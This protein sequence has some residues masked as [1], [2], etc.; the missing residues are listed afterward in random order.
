MKILQWTKDDMIRLLIWLMQ[1]HLESYVIKLFS[2]YHQVHPFHLSSGLLYNF[3]LILSSNY[4]TQVVFKLNIWYSRNNCIILID[5]CYAACEFRY[6][7]EYAGICQD[8]CNFICLDEKHRV[9]V[10]EP[11]ISVAAVEQGR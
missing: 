6:I 7:H 10:G 8:F 11:E 1:Y 3:G 9:K 2:C 4:K 5:S